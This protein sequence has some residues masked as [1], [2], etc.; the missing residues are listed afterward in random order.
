MEIHVL[1]IVVADFAGVEEEFG[2]LRLIFVERAFHQQLNARAAVNLKKFLHLRQRIAVVFQ[3]FNQYQF[4]ARE[5]VG[6]GSPLH[7]QDVERVQRALSRGGADFI[8]ELPDGIDTQLGRLFHN[9]VELSGGQWQRIALARAFMREEADI[10]ILDEPTAALDATAER[11]IFERFRH[12]SQGR[13]A[14]LISHRFP[15]V[16]MADHIVVLESSRVIEQGTH[17]A[18]LAQG[19]Q[20]ATMFRLQAQGYQ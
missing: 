5:N 1:Q 7:A 4:S 11:E 13:T 14:L 16:R 10:L 17:D 9:G 3:D 18:L 6:F 20:Y 2:F 8:R 12:L 19:G 15:T